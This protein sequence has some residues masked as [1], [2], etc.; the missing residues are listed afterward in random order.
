MGAAVT[1]AAG[2]TE[3]GLLHRSLQFL[4]CPP[5]ASSPLLRT[6]LL[7]LCDEGSPLRTLRGHSDVLQLVCTHLWPSLW[8]H[9]S[10]CDDVEMMGDAAAVSTVYTPAEV[11]AGLIARVVPVPGTKLFYSTGRSESAVVM[12]GSPALQPRERRRGGPCEECGEPTICDFVSYFT[13]FSVC[14][15]CKLQFEHDGGGP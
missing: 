10:S 8:A 9:L 14:P 12:C 2:K 4:I 3:G 6:L 7:G 15:D 1:R 13:Y 11:E 5:S